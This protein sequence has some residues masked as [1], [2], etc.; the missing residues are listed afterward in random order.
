MK[1]T[2][3]I[4]AAALL[5]GPAAAADAPITAT[6]KVAAAQD[7]TLSPYRLAELSAGNGAS[8]TVESVVLAPSGGGPAVREGPGL[9]RR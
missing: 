6:L 3:A 7:E 1:A 5:A 8:A 2:W 4:L 9:R